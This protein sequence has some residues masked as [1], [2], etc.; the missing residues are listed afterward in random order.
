MSTG[1]PQ[2]V[3]FRVAG[4]KGEGYEG[5]EAAGFVLQLAKTQE[6][7]DT[8]AVRFEMSVEHGGVG[9]EAEAVGGAHRLDPFVG[10]RLAMTEIFS[11]GG[12]ED[13]GASTGH[14]TEAG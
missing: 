5:L 6:V 4:V 14:G 3:E 13:L 12:V 8:V 9:S 7:V 10:A 1:T 2:M 11:Q